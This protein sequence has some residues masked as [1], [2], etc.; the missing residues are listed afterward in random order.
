MQTLDD[1]QVFQD[2]KNIAIERQAL[3]YICLKNFSKIINLKRDYFTR[4][5]HKIIF[6]IVEG[7][8]SRLTYA[9]AKEYVEKQFEK[10]ENAEENLVVI[11]KIFKTKIDDIDDKLF[12]SL[13]LSLHEN[14][15]LRKSL[16]LATEIVKKAKKKDAA[17]VRDEIRAYLAADITDK[18]IS[19]GEFLDGFE[20]RLHA[21]LY[22]RENPDDVGCFTG[23]EKIDQVLGPLKPGEF[24]LII[25]RTGVGKSI[26]AECIGIHNYVAAKK[27]VL[28]VSLEMPKMQV[29]N[30]A[31][32]YI[33][34][35]IYKGFRT[36]KMSDEEVETWKAKIKELRESFQNKFYTA[37]MRRST[38]AD[39]IAAEAYRLQDEM[40]Q[41]FDLIIIDYLN[42]M[43]PNGAKRASKQWDAMSDVSW[44]IKCLAQEFNDI[45]IPIWTPNQMKKDGTVKYGEAIAEHCPFVLRLKQDMNDEFEDLIEVEFA[46]TRDT[47]NILSPIKLVPDL[48]YMNIAAR[49][50]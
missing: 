38:S 24:G 4:E 39:E 10:E 3:A 7:T 44:D 33:A 34:H 15:M 25:G 27:N 12:E 36:G 8:K 35:V 42:L 1:L 2:T 28:F 46:K 47:E 45:G 16:T 21:L 29:F 5:P 13:V 17:G 43:R 23:V 6:D 40:K 18:S 37:Y 49:S 30:R 14:L 19:S 31:D 41:P 9:L 26:L 11:K 48:D 20:E 50:L 32:A 22:M